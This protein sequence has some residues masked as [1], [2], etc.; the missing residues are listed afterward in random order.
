MTVR[1]YGPA[2]GKAFAL[3]GTVAG[4]GVGIGPS[5]SGVLVQGLGWRWVFCS[6]PSPWRRYCSP[7]RRSSAGRPSRAARAPASMF[8]AAPSSSSRC[9]C[10]PRPLCRVRSGAGPV[11][12][13]CPCSP[14]PWRSSPSS[15]PSRSATT[16]PCS[17]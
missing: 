5:L 14:G 11:A 9:C 15:P 3:F 7:C 12:A 17:T 16:T 8:S 1:R 4:I 2:R 10:S 6:T 13:C